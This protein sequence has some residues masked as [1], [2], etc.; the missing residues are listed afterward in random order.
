MGACSIEFTL[1][2][3]K[4]RQQIERAFKKRK[5]EDKDYNGHREGYSGDFQTVHEVKHHDKIFN[6]YNDAW[7]YCL[8][9][10][11]KW[12]YVIST[13]Y[14]D[15]DV[16]KDVKWKTLAQNVSRLELKEDV[17]DLKQK[18]FS[19]MKNAKSVKVTCKGCTSS[20]N[21]SYL[22]NEKCPICSHSLLSVTDQNKIAKALEANKKRLKTAKKA[23]ESY[24]K[25]LKHIQ[26]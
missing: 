6:S 5:R 11:Q 10:A 7:D 12:D 15:L 2:G 21:R 8:D 9:N 1:S 24:L 20:I 25:R 14:L 13:Y 3:K 26:L 22:K 17:K 4:T 16:S 18:L 23:L 19:Q